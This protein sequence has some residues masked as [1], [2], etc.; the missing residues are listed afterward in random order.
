MPTISENIEKLLKEKNIDQIVEDKIN[1]AIN[2]KIDDIVEV[3]INN[4]LHK[5]NSETLIK[6]NDIDQIIETAYNAIQKEEKEN[7]NNFDIE[8]KAKEISKEIEENKKFRIYNK[9][10][11][12]FEEVTEDNKDYMPE[13]IWLKYEV[14]SYLS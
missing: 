14:G 10:T 13:E 8:E 1:A 9:L 11:N 6:E 12:K 4:I 7:V 3:A 5:E 2:S